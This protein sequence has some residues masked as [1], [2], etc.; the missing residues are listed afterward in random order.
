MSAGDVRAGGTATLLGF[1]MAGFCACGVVAGLLLVPG[2][3]WAN[4]MA[5][6]TSMKSMSVAVLRI[7]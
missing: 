4:T 3:F 6:A 7:K 2:G 1:G 5:T